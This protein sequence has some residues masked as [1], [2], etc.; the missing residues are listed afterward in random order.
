MG[1]DLFHGATRIQS[2]ELYYNRVK[3]SIYQHI[4]IKTT[5]IEFHY[6]RIEQ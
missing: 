3:P 5:T 1:N 6:S 4:D 2:L